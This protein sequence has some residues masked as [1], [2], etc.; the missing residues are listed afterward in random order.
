MYGVEAALLLLCSCSALALLL[1]SSCSALALLLLSSVLHGKIPDS[2]AAPGW[3]APRRNLTFH[4]RDPAELS[5]R[6][7]SRVARLANPTRGDG[8]ASATRLGRPVDEAGPYNT[9]CSAL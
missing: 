6:P 7:D 8:T 5:L 3:R 9:R 2:V 4:F 1:L